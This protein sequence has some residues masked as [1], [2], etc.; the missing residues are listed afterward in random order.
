MRPINKHPFMGKFLFYAVFLLSQVVWIFYSHT[1]L[2]CTVNGM[3]ANCYEPELTDWKY[4]LCDKAGSFNYRYRAWCEAGGGV[5]R[6]S[7]YGC[8][9]S[10]VFNEGN[11]VSFVSR[12]ADILSNTQ[13]SIPSDTGWGITYTDNYLCYSG[14]PTYVNDILISDVRQ[15]Q[16]PGATVIAYRSRELVCGEGATEVTINQKKLCVYKYIAAIPKDAPPPLRC[17]DT[18]GNPIVISTGAK[19]QKETDVYSRGKN[20]IGFERTYNN[21]D[22]NISTSWLNTYQKSLQFITPE[23]IATESRKSSPYTNKAQACTSGWSQIKSILMESWAISTTAQ[24][25]NGIC[26]IKRGNIIVR[27][28]PILPNTNNIQVY[29]KPGSVQVIRENGSVQSFGLGVGEQYVGFNGDHGQLIAVIDAAPVAW[30]YIASNGEVEDYNAD[31]KLLSITAS[32]GM[33]QELFY[34]AS[35]GLLTRVKDSTNRELTFAYTVN[36][37]SSV[38][39]D[40]NK[41][42]SYTY[43]GQGLI[44]KVIR[45]DNSER[46]YHYEDSRFPSFLT[47]ITDERGKRYATWAYDA[48]GRAISS[49]HAG[50]V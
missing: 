30:R 26:Q 47:G 13:G 6:G 41:T 17:D 19:I 46:I 15:L 45:P 22:I 50:G 18:V 48:Q 11:I 28:I 2:A 40:G 14:K 10:V 35:S 34:D 31:G 39:V 12:F 8:S 4:N 9:N 27:N 43:N 25:S 29:L 23:K 20:Q 1:A 32:N 3:D 42:T 7:N 37:L 36:Q 33:K 38:T 5:W 49:E 16:A 21:T 24:Y 44:S